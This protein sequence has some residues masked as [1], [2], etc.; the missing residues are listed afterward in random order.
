MTWDIPCKMQATNPTTVIMPE[1]NQKPLEA[2]D[3][4]APDLLFLEN[5]HHWATST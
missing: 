3:I 1:D 4:P 2:L 5:A